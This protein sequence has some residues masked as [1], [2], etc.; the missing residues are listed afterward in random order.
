M[1]FAIQ[2]YMN[3]T[4]ANAEKLIQDCGKKKTLPDADQLLFLFDRASEVIEK[5]RGDRQ[6]DQ[7]TVEKALESLSGARA[8][9][10]ELCERPAVR[11]ELSRTV[12]RADY[13]TMDK[14]APDFDAQMAALADVNLKDVD[15]GD[16]PVID[17]PVADPGFEE[18]LK[19]FFRR[20]LFVLL[21]A[22]F[23]YLIWKLN[24]FTL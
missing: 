16:S 9:V 24:G 7:P 18:K 22:G 17:V 19:K 6:A 8:H 13:L 4:I 20:L 5:F 15:V 11:S 2:Q 14:L 10:K 3:C 12:S 23:V 1:N 21:F